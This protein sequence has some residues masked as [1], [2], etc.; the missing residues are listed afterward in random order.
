[1]RDRVFVDFADTQFSNVAFTFLHEN[2]NLCEIV[3]ACS[4]GAQVESCRQK[5]C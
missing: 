5:N 3:F 4:Y 1:M 2:E